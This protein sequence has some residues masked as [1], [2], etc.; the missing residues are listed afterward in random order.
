[1]RYEAK[2]SYFKRLAQSMGDFINVP[3]SLTMRHRFL[4]CCESTDDAE[5]LAAGLTVGPGTDEALV[6]MYIHALFVYMH[7]CVSCNN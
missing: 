4:R 3:Y 2:H 7:R 6:Y 1:M 5:M